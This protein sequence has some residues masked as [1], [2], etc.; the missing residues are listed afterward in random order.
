MLV[1]EKHILSKENPSNIVAAIFVIR[2]D[3]SALLQHRDNKKGIR[4]PNI[5]GPP[6]GHVEDNETEL[7]CAKRELF[8]ETNYYEKNLTFLR[9]VYDETPGEPVYK[10][11][12]FWCLFDYV[13]VPK[14]NEG[15]DLRF[16]SRLEA[17]SL[18]IKKFI[19]EAWDDALTEANI[20]V[21]LPVIKN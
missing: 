6:G 8:E 20:S 9:T 5:W 7:T 2:T 12:L 13:Q 4:D 1:K 18:P 15:Q 19:I 14:C 3:G 21:K 17:S 16:V 10:V 11:A